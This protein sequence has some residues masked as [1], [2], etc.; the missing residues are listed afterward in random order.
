[1]DFVTIRIKQ[2]EEKTDLQSFK[3]V[4]RFEWIMEKKFSRFSQFVQ[5]TL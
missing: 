4:D 2:I 3:T 5:I 1:M